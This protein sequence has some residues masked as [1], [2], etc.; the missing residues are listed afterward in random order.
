MQVIL[1]GGDEAFS[2]ESKDLGVTRN[3]KIDFE[4]VIPF[5]KSQYENSGSASLKRWAKEFMDNN[6]VLFVM[7]IG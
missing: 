3:Y 5:I 2:I 1:K 6:T 7:A 4:G